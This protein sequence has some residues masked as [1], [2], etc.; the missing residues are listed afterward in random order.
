MSAVPR[1]AADFFRFGRGQIRES[2]EAARRASGVRR[3]TKRAEMTGRGEEGLV[4]Y[5]RG[6]MR[7]AKSR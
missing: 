5:T 6:M 1:G 2:G 7:L 3:S 4:T